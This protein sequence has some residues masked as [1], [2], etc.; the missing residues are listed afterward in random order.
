MNKRNGGLARTAMSLG[1]EEG[2]TYELRSIRQ[3]RETI[4]GRSIR[5]RFLHGCRLSVETGSAGVIAETAHQVGSC[6]PLCDARL[7]TESVS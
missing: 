1:S 6:V 3:G 2:S 7:S 4:A 5:Q